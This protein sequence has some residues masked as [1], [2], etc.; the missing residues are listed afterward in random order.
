MQASVVRLITRVSQIQGVTRSQLTGT[1]PHTAHLD[2]GTEHANV[3]SRIVPRRCS[4]RNNFI[5]Q[6]KLK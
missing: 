1:G 2:M 6:S 3:I 4:R 5:V